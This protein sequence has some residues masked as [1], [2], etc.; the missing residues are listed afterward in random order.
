MSTSTA[1]K[2]APSTTARAPR[3]TPPTPPT[4][5]RS[6]QRRTVAEG[7]WVVGRAD[8]PV[9]RILA[10]AESAPVVT[11][12]LPERSPE[13]IRRVALDDF[14]APEYDGDDVSVRVAQPRPSSVRLTRRGRLVV[15]GAG[16]LAALGVAFVAA[17]GSLANDKPEP[18]RVVMVQPG[19][20]LW[21]LASRAA[22]QTGSGDVRSM[23]THIETINHLDSATLQVG[24]TL[25]LPK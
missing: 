1:T 9:L 5:K 25:R 24:Q 6:T 13:P 15:V 22:V 18:T 23:M 14:F 7:A 21:D 12:V 8:R 20:T 17:T 3:L 11:R 4:R 2:Q 16:L 10:D 19:Q